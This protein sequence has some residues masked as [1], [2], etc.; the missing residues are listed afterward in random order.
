MAKPKEIQ[1]FNWLIVGSQKTGKTVSALFLASMLQRI[2]FE[3]GK[4]KRVI[5]FSPNDYNP[6]FR[7]KSSIQEAINLIQPGWKMPGVFHRINTSQILEVAHRKSNLY[8][9]SIVVK[10]TLE[11]FVNEAHQLLDYIILFDDMN[12]QIKGN[13]SSKKFDNLFTIVAGNRIKSNEVLF[14]YHTFHQ[15]PPSL[16]T[17]F[18]RAIIKE[19]DEKEGGIG[20]RKIEKGQEVLTN[21]Q[22][23][24]RRMN[25]VA[26]HP[27][28]LRLSELIV[29]I[30]EAY[31]FEVIN[32]QL[33][34]KIGSVYYKA[35]MDDI[36]P[37]N[38]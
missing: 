17:Y 22:M 27:N 32:G 5:I 31:I 12:N 28:R 19:T 16:W 3:H 2:A 11:E 36:E 37:I 20:F 18:Q 24:V 25:K 1:T 29:W 33:V 35:V 30:N 6:V 4:T 9:W 14:T 23:R 13:L 26:N 38:P 8:D 34:T 15:V 10:G 7:L 21:A